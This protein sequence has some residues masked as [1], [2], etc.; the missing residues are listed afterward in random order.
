MGTPE[1]D[2]SVLRDASGVAI[3][4]LQVDRPDAMDD[5]YASEDNTH[6]VRPPTGE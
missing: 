5:A 1:G 3:A 2:A 6:A 4:L